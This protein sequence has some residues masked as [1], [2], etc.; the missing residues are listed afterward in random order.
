[1]SQHFSEADLIL[2][3]DRSIY[4]LNLRAEHI[5]DTII[6]VGDPSRV[7]KVTQY[8]DKVEFEMNK[9]E[10]ITHTGF[11]KGK[12]LTVISSGMGTDNVEILLTELDAIVNIDFEKRQAREAH[13]SLQ[14]VR[15]GTSGSLQAAIGID[16]FVASDYAIGLDTLMCFYQLPQDDFEQRVGQK[17]QETLE[18]PFRPYCVKGDEGLRSRLAFDMLAGNTLTAPGFYAP[19]GRLLR[20]PIQYPQL[21]RTLSYFHEEDFWLTNFEMETAGYYALARLLGH[22]MISLNAILANRITGEFSKNPDKTVDA[23]IR[24]TLE[25]LVK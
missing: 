12:R 8:F 15:V 4:H 6:A 19:Q 5:A 2:N 7:H 3:K 1:M 25:R 14:I 22:Q 20:L 9:R 24:Q 10:F 23:L 16:S 18:L 21:I 13:R 17:I 11:Y